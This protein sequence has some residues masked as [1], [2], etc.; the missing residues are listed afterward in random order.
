MLRLIR[1]FAYPTI[2]YFLCRV[3]YPDAPAPLYHMVT[4]PL[5]WGAASAVLIG[6]KV[7]DTGGGGARFGEAGWFLVVVL[8]LGTTF[9]ARGKRPMERLLSGELPRESDLRRGAAALGLDPHRFPLA[10]VIDRFPD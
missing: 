8:F 5:L 6:L 2:G 9:P 1:V 4:L 7:L 3:A 10:Q